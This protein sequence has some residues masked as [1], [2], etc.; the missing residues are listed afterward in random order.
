MKKEKKFNN[1]KKENRI[2]KNLDV[3]TWDDVEKMYRRIQINDQNIKLLNGRV[4]V[5]EKETEKKKHHFY[6][7]TKEYQ[8]RQSELIDKIDELDRNL[9][10]LDK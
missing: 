2:C 7:I 10:N 8:E 9:T 3:G 5:L 4:Q 6:Q 1:L